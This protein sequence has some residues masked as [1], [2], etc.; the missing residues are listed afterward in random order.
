MCAFSGEKGPPFKPPKKTEIQPN[1]KSS[2][3]L[4]HKLYISPNELAEHSMK[5]YW[6]EIVRQKDINDARKIS[7][8][9]GS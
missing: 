6:K 2:L 7:G 1:F 9:S 8:K 4:L 5:Q 3:C